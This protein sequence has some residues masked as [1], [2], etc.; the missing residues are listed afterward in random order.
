M[1]QKFA[2]GA[3]ITS[4]TKNNDFTKFSCRDMLAHVLSVVGAWCVVEQIM[5]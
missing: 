2:L 5:W 3:G 4:F 1:V